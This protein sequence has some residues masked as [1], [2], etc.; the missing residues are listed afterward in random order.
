MFSKK[1][2][3]ICTIVLFLGLLWMFLPHAAH[4]LIISEVEET[5][6]YEHIIQGLIPTILSL[7][8]MILNEKHSSKKNN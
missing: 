8:V 1:I 7:I 5:E 4:N 2:Y 6:H 3:W